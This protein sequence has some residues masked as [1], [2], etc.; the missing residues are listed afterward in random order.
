[1][2]AA[3]F[4]VNDGLLSNLSLIMGVAGAN[5]QPKFVLLAGVT[6]LLA[7]AFSMA[8][9]EY[10]SM[11]AQRELAEREINLERR[12]LA[13]DAPGEQQELALIYQNKGLSPEDARQV[14]ALLMT[15]PQIALDTHVREELGL[16][17]QELGR[18]G[19]RR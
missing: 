16:N 18:R 8:A 19:A 1:M 10:I 13:A 15:S 14:A 12:E 5:A 11:S 2:R 4:G 3:V 9:G 17:P 6:G 7:G